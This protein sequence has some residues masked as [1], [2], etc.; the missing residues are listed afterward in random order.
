[1]YTYTV[2]ILQSKSFNKAMFMMWKH[3]TNRRC[4]GLS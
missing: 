1:M 3:S 2:V 4:K